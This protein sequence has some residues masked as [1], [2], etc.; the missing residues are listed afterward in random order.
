MVIRGVCSHLLHPPQAFTGTCMEQH[1]PGFLEHYDDFKRLGADEL[2]CVAVNDAF[3]QKA[4]GQHMD[5]EKKMRFLADPRAELASALG[6]TMDATPALGNVRFRRF[7]AFVDDGRVAVINPEEG[8]QLTVST[9]SD[10]LKQMGE[11]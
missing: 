9:A 4:F 5:P 7:S 6:L 10:L 2:W 3:V 8:G 1:V 11:R